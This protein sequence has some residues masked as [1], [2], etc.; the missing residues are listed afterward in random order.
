MNE[1]KFKNQIDE[2]TASR[3]F[4]K[5]G[6]YVLTSIVIVLVLTVFANSGNIR[7]VVVPPVLTKGFWLDENAADPEYIR[8]MAHYFAG[9][10]LNVHS[11]SVDFNHQQFLKF[12]STRAHPKLQA[13]L[14]AEAARIKKSNITQQFHPKQIKILEGKREAAV[15]GRR[16]ASVGRTETFND[17][18]NYKMEFSFEDGKI[19][20]TNFE[21]ADLYDPF[22]I[23]QKEAQEKAAAIGN[24]SGSNSKP[25]K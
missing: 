2:I 24:T 25:S 20:V 15:L 4:H 8:Q 6:N 22:G 21:K 5:K 19:V 16:I 7:T 1:S 18:E 9:L 23:K 11:D 3:N 14:G 10:A 17:L 13:E 12:T